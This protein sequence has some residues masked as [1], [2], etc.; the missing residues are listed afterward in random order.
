MPQVGPIIDHPPLPPPPLPPNSVLPP[1]LPQPS[2]QTPLPQPSMQTASMPVSHL[3]VSRSDVPLGGIA[4][5]SDAAEL[6]GE[7]LIEALSPPQPPPQLP[8]RVGPPQPPE[9]VEISQP[10]HDKMQAGHYQ[11]ESYSY[12]SKKENAKENEAVNDVPAQSDE[13]RG[14]DSTVHPAASRAHQN[15]SQSTRGGALS[16]LKPEQRRPTNELGRTPKRDEVTPR[17]GREH[18]V[19]TPSPLCYDGMRGER[20]LFEGVS[21]RELPIEALSLFGSP[22]VDFLRPGATNGD[23]SHMQTTPNHIQ[24]APNTM[25]TSPDVSSSPGNMRSSSDDMQSSPTNMH[26][27]PDLKTVGRKLQAASGVQDDGSMGEGWACAACTLVN[28][29]NESRCAV[30]DA[31]RGCTLASAATLAMQ[32]RI[33]TARPAVAAK[34]MKAD[35]KGAGSREQGRSAAPSGRTTAKP[36][37]VRGQMSILGFMRAQTEPR[38]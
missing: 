17:R 28:A 37:L 33:Q 2:M 5:D 23:A 36:S 10:P 31:L 30:C 38:S 29:H 35:S 25:Q 7:T 3:A 9:P 26:A 21:P 6:R 4:E 34:V 11:E 32:H 14:K 13:G 27:S 20:G 1:P 8:P 24:S 19:T 16:R 22:L 12:V 18:P 15:R